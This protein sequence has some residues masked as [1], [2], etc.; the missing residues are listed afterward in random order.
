[1]L[2][3]ITE[4]MN[5]YLSGVE[6][7]QKIKAEKLKH[8]N[9]DYAGELRAKE[10]RKVIEEFEQCVNSMRQKMLDTCNAYLYA[11]HT[12][13][14]KKINENL[15]ADF[16]AKLTALNAA[17]DAGALT[18]GYVISVL[19]NTPQYLGKSALLALAHKNNILKELEYY[20]P[21]AIH[22]AIA[23]VA[24][25]VQ[26]LA[27]LDASETNNLHAAL[28]ANDASIASTNNI[29]NNFVAGKYE[30]QTLETSV[31]SR[32]NTAE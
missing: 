9:S 27:N 20:A 28:L 15:S 2:S 25:N 14:D 23:N 7:Q 12:G 30:T 18:P 8:V 1:M 31:R 5:R 6:S 17:A 29:V 13:V 10:E 32:T 24:N 3:N 16:S 19:N 4:T 21:D 26:E 22:N 11:A